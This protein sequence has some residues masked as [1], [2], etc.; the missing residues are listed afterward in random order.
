MTLSAQWRRR[1]SGLVIAGTALIL[2]ACT[3]T[4]TE[5]EPVRTQV[6]ETSVE[7]TVQRR[8]LQLT[9]LLDASTRASSEVVI[10]LHG[11]TRLV[12]APGIATGRSV[13]RGEPIGEIE[14]EPDVQAQ[15][16]AAAQTN[17]LDEATLRGLNSFVAP[18]VAPIDGVL[19]LDGRP[20]IETPGID[21]ITPLTPLQTLRYSATPFVGTATVETVVGARN[22]DC[23]ALWIDTV[24]GEDGAASQL[25]C[26]LPSHV[27]TAAGLRAQLKIQSAVREDVV[28]V[29]N[30]YLKY[31]EAADGYVILVDDDGKATPYSVLAGITDGVVREVETEAP[32]GSRLVRP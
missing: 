9:Y 18:Y 26:R 25:H 23:V 31:D 3:P 4:A 8:D 11:A 12:A 24:D 28:V 1:A 32:I 6:S 30:M 2:A 20:R 10:G 17:K 7:G 15:L 29:P 14:I 16:H 27:E 5:E 13:A 21:V 22:V 19:N